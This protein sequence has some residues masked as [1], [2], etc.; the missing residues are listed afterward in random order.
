MF[1][2]GRG[3]SAAILACAGVLSLVALFAACGA[4]EPAAPSAA[5]CERTSGA[6]RARVEKAVT[7]NQ[8]CQ[9]DADC[10]V[11]P[12]NATCFDAC[13]TAVNVTGRGAVDRAST[14]VEA[15]ECKAWKD[16]GCTLVRP[17]CAPPAA[18]VCRQGVCE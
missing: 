5:V 3:G 14:L 15:S 18:P 4:G 6:A 1:A 12:V 17:P 9:S 2:L 13:T 10:V 11:T 8:T 16:T 7:E